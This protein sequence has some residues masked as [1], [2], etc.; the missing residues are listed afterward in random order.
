M[1][2]VRLGELAARRGAHRPRGSRPRSYGRGAR[3]LRIGIA[4]TGL[5]TFAYFAV[6]SHVLTTGDYGRISLLWSM[7]FVIM[8]VIYRPV[9]QLL[10]RT[11]ADA[12][13]ARACTAAIRCA[14]PR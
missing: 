9:E 14:C 5:F 13:R 7:L 3:I 12:P 8:S 11:I 2:L 1:L 10:S 4:S 6:A